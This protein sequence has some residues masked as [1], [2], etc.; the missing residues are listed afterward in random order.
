VKDGLRGLAHAGVLK[1]SGHVDICVKTMVESQ[2]P[3]RRGEVELSIVI[4]NWNTR[5]LLV[6]CLESVYAHSPDGEFEVFV[7][8]NASTDGSAQMVRERFPQVQLI[9]NSENVGFARANNQVITLAKG[10]YVLL[11]NSDAIVLPGAIS[12]MV[13][14]M[15]QH[16][17]IGVLGPALLDEEENVQPSWAKFPTIWSELRGVH[18]RDREPFL[19]PTQSGQPVEAYQVD[20]MAG[21]C[22]LVRKEAIEQVGLMDERFFLYSEETDW[23][24]R[25]KAAGWHNVYYPQA[26]VMHFEGSSSAQDLSRTYFFLYHSKILYMHKHFGV[27]RAALLRTGFAVL[28]AGKA[29]LRL[30]L[31]QP[32]VAQAH[33]MLA[34]QL[35]ERRGTVYDGPDCF[36]HQYK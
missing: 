16:A 31:R 26:R 2:R 4:V 21:A 23:C 18:H 19:D 24:W 7:V 11:L 29:L 6:Q 8:D 35:F 9:E 15:K 20:W 32:S 22:L 30:I 28:A 14:F 34:K 36:Y 13:M 1:T 25:I 27:W 33:W 17:R 5:D 10:R 3:K 12:A